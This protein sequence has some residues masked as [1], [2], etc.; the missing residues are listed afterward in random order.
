MPDI[1][2]EQENATPDGNDEASYP[3]RELLENPENRIGGY[4]LSTRSAFYSL[5]ESNSPYEEISRIIRVMSEAPVR[6]TDVAKVNTPGKFSE[7]AKELSETAIQREIYRQPCRID[8]NEVSWM[9]CESPLD[10]V[11]GRARRTCPDLIGFDRDKITWIVDLKYAPNRDEEE[12]KDNPHYGDTPLLASLKALYYA[13]TAYQN[14]ANIRK[15]RLFHK[16]S[17]ALEAE[18]SVFVNDAAFESIC[19]VVA[20]DSA[21][22]K[23]WSKALKDRR[24]TR[25]NLTQFRDQTIAALRECASKFGMNPGARAFVFLDYGTPAIKTT[26]AVPGPWGAL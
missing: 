19:A 12:E 18:N 11:T 23:R 8:G 1:S 14:R 2:E 17:R 13:R 22:W 5:L 20:A 15:Y 10:Y 24:R 3:L 25:S 9:D 4:S 21:Y 6:W 16:N 7:D 26:C